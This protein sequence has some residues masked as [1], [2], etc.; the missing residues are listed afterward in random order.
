M[1]CEN[2]ATVLRLASGQALRA[3]L[4]SSGHRRRC[5]LI[6]GNPGS[7][8]DWSLVLELLS[9]TADVVAIDLP[10]FGGSARPRDG[11]QGL[12]LDRLAE[13]VAAV[14]DALAWETPIFVVGHSHGGGVAQTLAAKHPARIAGI[15]L[16][17]S[18]GSPTHSSYRLLAAP[19]ATVVA[20]AVGALLG[21][22]WL[23]PIGGWVIRRALRDIAA[24]EAVSPARA[25]RELQ[26]LTARPEVL[27]SM[28]EAAL[29]R[30]CDQLLASAF[31]IQC[32]VLF[33]HGGRDRL[34]PVEC[35]RLVHRKIREA[36]GV[37]SFEVLPNAGHMLP[38]FQ[39]TQVAV[40]IAQF[41]DENPGA[42]T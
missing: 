31:A 27:V 11:R 6:H 1:A 40:R 18:L 14:A 22:K 30:P 7:L 24:P 25:D 3:V 36:R 35:A 9:E 21:P 5:I 37:S 32:S 26:Q 41:M 12:S 16:L 17:G 38:E 33:L 39:A 23:R 4:R 42:G 8:R 29:G 34:V 19:G 20:R 15:V 28:V 2:E 13:C 10:G